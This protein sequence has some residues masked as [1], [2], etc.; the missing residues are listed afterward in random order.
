MEEN[1]SF[2]NLVESLQT[3]RKELEVLRSEHEISITDVGS[4][5]TGEKGEGE[6]EGCL[7][8]E[9]MNAVSRYAGIT[10][11]I[12]DD[13]ENTETFLLQESKEAVL[14]E[15]LNKLNGGIK[16]SEVMSKDNYAELR[17]MTAL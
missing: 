6:H 1:W 7:F 16:E 12:E 4:T 2:S 10:F 15:S 14:A 8:L 11:V 17:L 13:K 3:V 5:A 9:T